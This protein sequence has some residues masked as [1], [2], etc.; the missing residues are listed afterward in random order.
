MT[1]PPD[2][3]RTAVGRFDVANSEDPNRLVID[4]R[5]ESVSLAGARRM[6]EWLE[7]LVPDAS[8]ALRLAVRCHHLCRWQFP[9][10][11]YPMTR[12]GYHQWRTA[13]AKFHAEKAGQIL[14]EVGYG[15]DT[16]ARVQA[17]VRKEGLTTDPETRSL[18]DA[19]CLVFLESGFAEFA[20][21]YDEAKII[22]IV[23]RTWRKMSPQ[24]RAAA[25]GLKLPAGARG[26]VERALA[27][28]PPA[29]PT[30]DPSGA[31]E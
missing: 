29:A 23:Q 26:L 24:G 25:L 17:L 13:A 22:G 28:A 8:E 20:A 14:R 11:R 3:F 21:R 5:D 31:P 10:D 18:E 4:G 19:A 12:A 9:R 2:R 16:I 27:P 15:D 7:R 30:G 6:S 1:H